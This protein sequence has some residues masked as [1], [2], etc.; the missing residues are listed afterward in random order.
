LQNQR[1]YTVHVRARGNLFNCAVFD[2]NQKIDS[3][4]VQI[5]T[6]MRGQVGFATWSAPM[7]FR[8][9]K[10]TAPDG[11]V[12]VRGVSDLSTLI[13]MQGSPP[14]PDTGSNPAGSSASPRVVDLL[15]TIDLGAASVH[16]AWRWTAAHQLEAVP[17]VRL[18]ILRTAYQPPEE[19]D[20]QIDFDHPPDA[21]YVELTVLLV[22]GGTRCTLHESEVHGGNGSTES[23]FVFEPSAGKDTTTTWHTSRFQGHTNQ[24]TFVRVRRNSLRA[25]VDGVLVAQTLTDGLNQSPP[26]WYWSGPEQTIGLVLSGASIH[27]DRVQVTEIT[28]KGLF[29]PL[30][31]LDQ[32]ATLPQAPPSERPER[33]VDL[34]P[35]INPAQDAV[36]GTWE[37]EGSAVECVR[38]GQLSRLK[39]NYPPPEEYNL[40]AVFTRLHDEMDVML[41]LWRNN[42]PI[43]LALGGDWN[44]RIMFDRAS[45]KLSSA[46]VPK[47]L[48]NGRKYDVMVY[49][50]KKRLA[51]SLNGKLIIDS[52]ADDNMLNE[53]SQWDI[54]PNVLGVGS[55]CDV[56]FSKL[57]IE[58]LSG[59]G[60]SLISGPSAGVVH[61]M[62]KATPAVSAPMSPTD[63]QPPASTVGGPDSN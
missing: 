36:A 1:W 48:F 26:P 50:R 49:V 40:H 30:S 59:A 57:Q 56:L 37:R 38:A 43:A 9:L 35:M 47:V 29:V 3:T 63:P 42:R 28:G 53:A 31:P 16:G 55:Y 25:Y 7:R 51:V 39:I 33:V 34:M 20:L 10:I 45:S 41:L 21:H 24:Q 6:L 27:V 52:P 2:G 13:T 54:G 8:N 5:D 4:D 60:R 11:K 14:A 18:G 62:P 12:L 23:N 19:Y 32:L 58:E 46:R 15:P 22:C 61:S 17:D 44:H